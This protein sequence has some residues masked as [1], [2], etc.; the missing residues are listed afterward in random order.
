MSMMIKEMVIKMM[1]IV[2]MMMIEMTMIKVVVMN[3]MMT[4]IK[5][6]IKVRLPNDNQD[7]GDDQDDDGQDDDYQDGDQGL[8]TTSCT[9]SSQRWTSLSLNISTQ[10]CRCS[11]YQ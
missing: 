4:R 3:K 11:C 5:K 9:T 8:A 1:L 6:V 2:N 10:H 7:D